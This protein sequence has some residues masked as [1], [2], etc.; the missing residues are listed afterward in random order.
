MHKWWLALLLPHAARL[1][2]ASLLADKVGRRKQNSSW[3]RA[4]QAKL[5]VAV[6]ATLPSLPP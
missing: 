6:A 3:A 4:C 1:G 2:L 5:N